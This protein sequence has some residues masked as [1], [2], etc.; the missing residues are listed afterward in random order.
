MKNKHVIVVGGGAAGLAAA[1]TASR[2]G[3]RVTLIEQKDRVG[4][5]ILSTGNGR[6]NLTNEHMTPDCFRGDDTSIVAE[7]LK[8]F[9]YEDTL[10]FF[11][12]LGVIVKNKQ[13]YIYPLSEQASTIL[14]VLR[15]EAERLPITILLEQSVTSVTKNKKGFQVK[16]NQSNIQG[17]AVILAA[18]GKASP[19]LGSD[20]SGYG[21]AKQFGHRLSPVVPALTA[22]KGKGNYFKQIAG[23]R[24]NAMVSVFVD[25]QFT[26]SD[27]GE[28]QLTNYG[29]SGIPVFQIS[30]YAAKALY[31]KK[32]VTVKIDFLPLMDEPSL[33]QFLENRKKMHTQ[34]SAEDF[35]VGMLHKKLIGMLLKQAHIRPDMKISDVK[36]KQLETWIHLCKQFVVEIEGIN[37]FEQAQ[38]CAGGVKTTEINPQTMESLLEEGLYLTGELMDIDGICGGYN[39]Q[40]AWST[41]YIAGKHAAKGNEYDSNRTTE[42]ITKSY[43]STTAS[44]SSKDTSYF[45]KR[46][47]KS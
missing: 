38:V 16:T 37:S 15:M 29:I 21:L 2:E 23:V 5:K 3:A 6:C 27:T 19:V 9:G 39:L 20:G 36:E 24:T 43:R 30:R 28:L 35:F 34:K 45:R 42:T 18:G 46:N 4:K 11:E 10:R 31:A 44:K 41:G 47:L 26:A 32:D 8:Q 13:G 22:L 7:V 12:D 25:G 33:K 1:I 17:D 14:D 40:W